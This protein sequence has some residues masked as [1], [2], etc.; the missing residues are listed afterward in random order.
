MF[1]ASHNG[2]PV[3]EFVAVGY[4]SKCLTKVRITWPVQDSESPYRY[5]DLIVQLHNLKKYFERRPLITTFEHSVGTYTGESFDGE[6]Y[7]WGTMD[8]SG[9][10]KFVGEWRDGTAWDV[11]AYDIDGSK[12][13]TI[14][15]GVNQ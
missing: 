1:K 11:T 2:I 12:M 7:G 14:L 13:G 3:D 10:Y 6:P 9:L 5:S 8:V 4:T 15:K